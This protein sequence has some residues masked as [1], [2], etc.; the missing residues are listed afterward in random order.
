MCIDVDS[1]ELSTA[2][3]VD[4]VDWSSQD[5]VD[6]YTGMPRLAEVR[7]VQKERNQ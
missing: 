2:S 7:N 1:V 3:T 6:T 5:F 4:A